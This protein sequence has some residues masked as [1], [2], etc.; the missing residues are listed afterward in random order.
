MWQVAISFLANK[1]EF[2]STCFKL[3][4]TQFFIT[5]YKAFDSINGKFGYY[6][7]KLKFDVSKNS[8][9]YF[10]Q[11]ELFGGAASDTKFYEMVCCKYH[12]D[13]RLENHQCHAN[14]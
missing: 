7:W 13:T 3:T 12:M 5:I 1:N 4:F 14:F 9:T 11:G 8:C 10:T 6:F 2:C